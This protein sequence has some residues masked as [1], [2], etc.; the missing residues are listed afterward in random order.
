MI[1]HREK[2][3]ICGILEEKRTRKN[4][5]VYTIVMGEGVKNIWT[6]EK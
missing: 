3:R 1:R 6:V 5:N 4:Q 2:K